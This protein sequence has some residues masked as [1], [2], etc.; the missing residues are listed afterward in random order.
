MFG[1]YPEFRNDSCIPG[2]G[3]RFFPFLGPLLIGGLAGYALGRPWGVPY[4]VPPFGGGAMCPPNMIFLGNQARPLPY[5]PMQPGYSQC[6]MSNVAYGQH[7][8]VPGEIVTS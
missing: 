7:H 5:S 8:Q 1:V 6:N 2:E 4:G 3:E